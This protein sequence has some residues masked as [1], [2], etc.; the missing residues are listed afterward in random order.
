MGNPVR[1]RFPISPLEAVVLLHNVLK[2]EDA[3]NDADRTVDEIVGEIDDLDGMIT[4]SLLE[5]ALYCCNM[6]DERK[7]FW[8]PLKWELKRFVKELLPHKYVFDYYYNRIEEDNG[9][10]VKTWR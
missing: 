4:K 1:T 3:E 9:L 5:S 8:H 2:C 6:E 7:Q 10:N